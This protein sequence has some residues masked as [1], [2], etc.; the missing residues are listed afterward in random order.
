MVVSALADGKVGIVPYRDAPTTELMQEMLGGRARVAW[1]AHVVP[2]PEGDFDETVSTLRF[3]TM[4]GKIK[5]TP[6]RLPHGLKVAEEAAEAREV[7]E[8]QKM[9]TSGPS[10]RRD[11]AE[12]P[13]GAN[14]TPSLAQRA[15][16]RRTGSGDGSSMLV[17]S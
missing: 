11:A 14:A 9:L 12:S 4:V 10:S 3:T 5:N 2:G 1:L 7:A 8:L 17:L 13:M 15:I 16:H 6:E